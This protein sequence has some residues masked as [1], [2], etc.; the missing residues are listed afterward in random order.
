MMDVRPAANQGPAGVGS[1]PR[2][3]LTRLLQTWHSSPAFELRHVEVRRLDAI[4]GRLN[5]LFVRGGVLLVTRNPDNV[6]L[7]PVRPFR[8]PALPGAEIPERRARACM[9]PTITTPAA[10]PDPLGITDIEV[11]EEVLVGRVAVVVEV[12]RYAGAIAENVAVGPA[13]DRR[14]LLGIHF[15]W[16][17]ARGSC[18]ARNFR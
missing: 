4:G 10:C 16:P 15:A 13:F 11:G 3:A 5:P 12:Q 18:E 8:E 9:R 6:D 2:T 7:R 14:R 1:D 17:S